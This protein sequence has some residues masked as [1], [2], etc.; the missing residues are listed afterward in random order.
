MGD[1]TGSHI[2]MEATKNNKFTSEVVD[3]EDHISNKTVTVR[4]AKPKITPQHSAEMRARARALV[5]LGVISTV[6]GLTDNIT[7]P[8]LKRITKV[9]SNIKD[10]EEGPITEFRKIRIR[11]RN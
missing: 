1:T 11:V 10:G 5:S 7:D 2:T 4:V 3:V 6:E 8:E 9:K